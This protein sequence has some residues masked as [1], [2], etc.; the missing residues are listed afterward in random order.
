M[1]RRKKRKKTIHLNESKKE[2]VEK[3]GEKII[4]SH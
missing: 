4:S 2:K 1:K 3:K